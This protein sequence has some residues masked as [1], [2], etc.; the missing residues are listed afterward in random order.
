MTKTPAWKKRQSQVAADI[1][2]GSNSR[3][4]IKRR[5][6]VLEGQVGVLETSYDEMRTYVQ[7]LIDLS[8][9]SED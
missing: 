1:R 9:L 5:L 8:D 2:H 4:L 6:A 7:K 3:S